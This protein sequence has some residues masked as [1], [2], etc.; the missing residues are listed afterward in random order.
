LATIKELANGCWAAIIGKMSA[1]GM[2]RT[3][4][5]VSFT[6]IKEHIVRRWTAFTSQIFQNTTGVCRTRAIRGIAAE[7]I[8]STSTQGS[9]WSGTTVAS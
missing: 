7:Q 9:R 4:G 8:D 6:A 5:K 3:F 2:C 1:L